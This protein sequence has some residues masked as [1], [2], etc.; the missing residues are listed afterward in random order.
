[1]TLLLL[2]SSLH[3]LDACERA[4]RTIKNASIYYVRQPNTMQCIRENSTAHK[5]IVINAYKRNREAANGTAALEVMVRCGWWVVER[6][7]GTERTLKECGQL[8]LEMMQPNINIVVMIIG[9]LSRTPSQDNRF[10]AVGS[11]GCAMQ[12]RRPLPSVFA[13]LPLIHNT[14]MRKYTRA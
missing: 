12:D 11:G 3:R 9:R 2:A 13:M 1:M 10:G 7:L 14:L 5:G 6:I 8:A 4:L